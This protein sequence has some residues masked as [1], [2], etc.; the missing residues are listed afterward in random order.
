MTAGESATIR[1]D[2]GCLFF[3]A[4]AWYDGHNR[5]GNIVE[6]MEKTMMTKRIAALLLVICLALGAGLA[7]AEVE[8]KECEGIK[9]PYQWQDYEL[10]VESVK[11]GPGNE[12]FT[13]SM[14]GS[15]FF[16]DGSDTVLQIKETMVGITLLG[17]EK[18]VAMADLDTEKLK[19]FVLKDAAGNVVPMYCWSWW[20]VEYSP[21]TGFRT[22]DTQEGFILFA[23]LPE[24]VDADGLVLT[25]EA[26][27]AE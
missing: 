25:V 20:G 18:G 10:T 23:Y 3:W 15:R 21:D 6:R 5:K 26:P 8:T 19:Q 14:M 22:F 1:E 27:A 12:L 7:A 13:G 16:G 9:G 11:V 24:G 17:G 4:E 2:F